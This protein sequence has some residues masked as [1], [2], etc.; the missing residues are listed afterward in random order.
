MKILPVG[1]G[2]FHADRRTSMTKL[3]FTLRNFVDAQK[4]AYLKRGNSILA[5]KTL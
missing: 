4:R 1:A 3:T 5:R 2:L